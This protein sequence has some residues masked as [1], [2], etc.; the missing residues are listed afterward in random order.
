VRIAVLIPTLCLA[1]SSLAA[2]AGGSDAEEPVDPAE[3]CAAL[4]QLDTVE[5]GGQEFVDALAR[6][7]RAAPGEIAEATGELLGFVEA[8]SAI[9]ALEG[10]ERTDA[11]DDLTARE[12]D[13]DA[14]VTSLESYSVANCPDLGE[15]LFG[16]G[17]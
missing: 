12:G 16:S 17:S 4:A 7:D 6:L 11:I 15:A 10:D 1:V 8:S 5:S 2:C 3:F 14:A 9:G 13:F